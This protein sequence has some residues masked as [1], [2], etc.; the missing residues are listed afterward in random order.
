MS[1][2]VSTGL[3]LITYQL[4]GEGFVTLPWPLVAGWDCTSTVPGLTRTALSTAPGGGL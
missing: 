3:S 4:L 1:A 2:P